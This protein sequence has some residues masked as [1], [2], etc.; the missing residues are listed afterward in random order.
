MKF[1]DF[2]DPPRANHFFEKKNNE[3]LIIAFG[4]DYEN[5]IPL[6][7]FKVYNIITNLC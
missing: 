7:D 5:K 2:I 4:F 6:N 1:V 3:E